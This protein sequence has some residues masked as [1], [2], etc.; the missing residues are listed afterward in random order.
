MVRPVSARVW[1]IPPG[2]PFVD[3]LA[4]GLGERYG[5]TPDALGRL[6]LLLP[7]RRACL[8]MRDAFLRHSDGAA[9]LLPRLVPLGDM[10]ADEIEPGL[11][12][13]LPESLAVHQAEPIPTAL[14]GLARTPL[15]PPPRLPRLGTCVALPLWGSFAR[16]PRVSFRGP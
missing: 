4:I 10:D 6:T 13:G 8:A 15:L 9:L 12:A 16:P 14:S 5:G 1:T 11:G 2:A 7:T 3:S